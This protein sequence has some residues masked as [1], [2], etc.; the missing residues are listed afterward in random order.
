MRRE[1]NGGETLP[2]AQRSGLQ[3]SNLRNSA[4]RNCVRLRKLHC[5]G[6]PFSASPQSDDLATART[7]LF[8]VQARWLHD[9]GQNRNGSLPD[10]DAQ[11]K[12]EVANT[13][14]RKPEVIE[15]RLTGL[16]LDA[17]ASKT[18][19]ANADSSKGWR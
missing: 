16:P 1:L 5:A 18:L 3:T 14:I 10:P 4:N 7:D 15:E 2:I 17:V 11:P 19:A 9:R 8:A 12:A 13:R 6:E